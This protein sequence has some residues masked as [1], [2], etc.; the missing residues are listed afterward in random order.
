M[1]SPQDPS[2]RFRLSD[3]FAS[4]GD[5]VE[6]NPFPLDAS[7]HTVWIEATRKAEE[8]VCTSSALL[9]LPSRTSE[10]WATTLILAKFDAWAERGASVVWSDRAVQHYDQWLVSYANSWL[11]EV[12]QIYRSA[13]PGD[14]VYGWLTR[15]RNRLGGQVHAWKAVARRACAEHQSTLASHADQPPDVVL[16][17]FFDL[18][19]GENAVPEDDPG[20]RQWI[21]TSRHLADELT[22][23]DSALWSTRPTSEDATMLVDSLARWTA[24]YFDA[25]AE[26]RLTI[27]VKDKSE[28]GEEAYRGVLDALRAEALRVADALKALVACHAE[29]LIVAFPGP[30]VSNTEC[31]ACAVEVQQRL[32]PE[33]TR[34]LLRPKTLGSPPEADRMVS[35]G[36][37]LGG[38][39]KG[40]TRPREPDGPPA[41]GPMSARRW[42]D[43][44]IRFL[45]DFTFQ[46]LVNGTIQAPQNYA[47]VGFGDGRHGKPRAAWETLRALAESGGVI[48]S[49]RTAAEWPKL[50]KR[51]QE[52]RRVLR[53]CFTLD[54]DPVPYVKG[55]YRTRFKI[56]LSASYER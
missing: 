38:G 33:V 34:R 2:E 20:H 52:I 26:A 46:A 48:A 8:A 45:S 7:L 28:A 31:L 30:T 54:G 47:D 43:V 15:L 3:S 32:I 19:L 35:S 49:T 10:D 9:N 14:P 17:R 11:D 24:A 22:R 18:F 41:H 1:S 6:G 36:A 16:S 25:T 12:A 23:I 4:V 21:E 51:I 37:K 27:V 53:G 50:E 5:P 39:S 13:P 29:T 55:G 44:E 42:E 56:R 40:P